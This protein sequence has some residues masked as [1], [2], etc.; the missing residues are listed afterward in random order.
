M[1]VFALASILATAS[2]T[3]A[4][5]ANRVDLDDTTVAL[6]ARFEAFKLRFSKQYTSAENVEALKVFAF[7]D[8]KIQNWNANSTVTGV[9]LG[10]NEFSDMTE[11][12]F[13][14]SRTTNIELRANEDNAN[15]ALLSAA[16]VAAGAAK[17]WVTDGAVTAVKNQ[18]RCGSCWAF[19]TT[20]SFEGAYQIAGNPLTAFSEQYLLDCDKVDQACNGGL[21]DNAFKQ[22]E[23]LGGLPTEA[24][25]PYLAAK[26]T[27][28]STPQVATLTGFTDVPTKSETALV[29]AL[30]K[31]PV[32]VAVEADKSVFQSYKSGVVTSAL[33]GTQLDHGVLAVGYGTDAGTDYYKVKN[34]WGATWGVAG[35]L[36]IERGS[37]TCGIE[38]QPSYPT[39]VKKT[40]GPSPPGP[41]P[42]TPTP[43]TPT[44]GPPTAT[45]YGDP[46]DGPCMSDELNIT[47]TGVSGAFC[48]PSCSIIKACPNDKP[49]GAVGGN[50]ECALEDSAADKKYCA[51]ICTPGA[52]GDAVC[53]DKASCKTVTASIG[54]CTYDQ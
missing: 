3:Q 50:P 16:P 31:G 35:Y 38:T 52:V 46:L 23:S 2:A 28:K 1:K 13:F 9:T 11:E 20:G 33:C 12:E 44:P 22:I 5:F 25:Y 34:S 40:S 24:S 41:S 17:D 42:P 47:V 53:G 36:K 32:S 8:Q 45:H 43:P 10:H 29:A 26:G 48:A 15:M 54:L 14:G 4:T 27:C 6:G 30:A 49:A 39:G 19:S 37:N 18:A 51:L 21:M 7:H